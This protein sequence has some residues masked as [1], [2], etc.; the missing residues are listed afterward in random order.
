[1]V[2]AET[3][4]WLD[5]LYPDEPETST[6]PAE[7]APPVEKGIIG[8]G[9]DIVKGILSGPVKE[10]ENVGQAVRDI[11]DFVDNK[12]L[13]G[14]HVQDEYDID[15]VPEAITPET[16]AGRTAQSISAFVTA[17]LAGGKLITAPLKGLTAMQKLSTSLPWAAKAVETIAK[18]GVVDFITG[19]GTDERFADVLVNNDILRNAFTEYLASDE[20]DSWAEARWKNVLEG[21]VVGGALDTGLATFRA[22]KHGYKAS[23]RADING[24]ILSR[25]EAADRII[26]KQRIADVGGA[27]PQK[28][29][30]TDRALM[31]QT[32]EELQKEGTE[33][34][35]KN[36]DY[37]NTRVFTN[38]RTAAYVDSL[39][40]EIGGMARNVPVRQRLFKG[41]VEYNLTHEADKAF[42]KENF[43]S[44]GALKD[45]DAAQASVNRLMFL[46]TWLPQH[47]DKAAQDIAD[48]APGALAK[49]RQM[50]QDTL[51][52]VIDQKNSYIEHGRVSDSANVLKWGAENGGEYAGKPQGQQ[53]IEDIAKTAKEAIDK[54]SDDEI[55]DFLLTYKSMAKSGASPKELMQHVA[56]L[57]SENSVLKQKLGMKDSPIWNSLSKFRYGM[58][59]SSLKTQIRAF[60]GNAA[61]VPLTVVEEAAKAMYSGAIEGYA[62]SGLS[63]AGVGALHGVREGAWYW[64]GMAKA[65][66]YAKENFMNSIKYG[67][68]IS[69]PANFA[70]G[71]EQAVKTY[72]WA[73]NALVNAPLKALQAAD[74]FFSTWAGGA[75]AY[76]K[77]MI[78]AHRSGVLKNADGSLKA[79]IL[80]RYVD[81][82]MEKSFSDVVMRDGTVVRGALALKESYDV[83]AE[84]VYQQALTGFMK[85][86]SDAVNR[87]WWLKTLFP[88]VKTPAN[89]TKDWL[90]TRNPVLA[91][92]K[93][94]EAYKSGDRAQLSEALTHMTSAVML[95]STAYF[96]VA[97]GKITGKGPDSPFQR[98]VLQQM[99]WSPNSYRTADGTYWSL[100]AIEPYG[101]LLGFLATWAE[102]SQRE[103]NLQLTDVASMM[104]ALSATVRDKT[105]LKGLHDVTELLAATPQ[106]RDVVA[107]VP[108]SFFPGLLRDMGQ[109]LDPVRRETPDFY[110]KALARTPFHAQLAPKYSWL[111]GMPIIYNHNGGLGAF[112]NVL[113]TS[114]EKGDAVFYELSRLKGVGDPPEKIGNYKLS[115]D[116]Y[117][118]LC[119][120]TG[121]IEL[122][123]R[124]LYQ[125]LEE[126]INSELYRKDQEIRPDPS[127]FEIESERNERIEKLI[128]DYQKAAKA[129]FMRD[130]PHIARASAPPRLQ[131]MTNF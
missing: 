48:N 3:Q 17:W 39:Q 29:E 123:G 109:A 110:E 62:Q 102:K 58:M 44:S 93:I 12:V 118:A 108:L 121:S 53:I 25:K 78:A 38:E 35:K 5:R 79:E 76:Q 117:A 30:L 45:V 49:A 1:M 113:N 37:F 106:A 24:S 101:S 70:E 96:L 105:F 107:N 122:N 10:V 36:T 50:A 65:F 77:A 81:E 63:G 20:D 67:E 34:L 99:G 26:A 103:G 15:I 72:K 120:L 129:R 86:F 13:D 125:S 41:A 9:V 66:K 92:F 80:S 40:E 83:A 115:P 43:L 90:I 22:M 85:T 100:D 68:A 21:F 126:L 64:S 94:Y 7:Q 124:T 2:D 95:W 130:H 73:D 104:Q 33:L 51:E 59:L 71:A 16:A 88:F 97:D 52:I 69:R 54:Q 8:T 116:E 114:K 31:Q 127:P 19:D 82:Y 112:F 119:E 56:K 111:T 128:R 18:N 61:R 131:N 23:L 87:H 6:Q 42:V 14:T 47:L 27:G 4:A 11:A 84:A 75:K 89:I 57:T 46:D 60:A 98:E 32:R 91:P 28:S 74:E 55:L